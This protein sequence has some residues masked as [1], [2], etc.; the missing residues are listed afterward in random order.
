[1]WA[2]AMH[3]VA[4]LNNFSEVTLQCLKQGCTNF[5]NNW[6]PLQGS[7]RQKGDM[8]QVSTNITHHHKT[9]SRHGDLAA[10]NCASLV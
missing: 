2:D 1:M 6:Q 5:P 10:A 9:L 3:L 8:K 4:Q 7:R